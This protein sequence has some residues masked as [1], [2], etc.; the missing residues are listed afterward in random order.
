MAKVE[1]CEAF[2]APS[3]LQSM[4]CGWLSNTSYWRGNSNVPGTSSDCRYSGSD[5]GASGI[6]AFHSPYSRHLVPLGLWRSAVCEHLILARYS[7]RINRFEWQRPRDTERV[8][9]EAFHS[10]RTRTI[11]SPCSRSTVKT[12]VIHHPRRPLISAL[13]QKLLGKFSLS[14]TR[15]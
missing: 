14:P 15:I 13:R 4:R 9:T 11:R 6:R 12:L 8:P 1:C 3:C 2:V 7:S 5:G 10:Q